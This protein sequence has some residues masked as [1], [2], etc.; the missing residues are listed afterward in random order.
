MALTEQQPST[1]AQP[2]PSDDAFEEV[3]QSF[4]KRLHGEQARLLV[5]TDALGSDIGNAALVLGDLEVFAHRLR[6]A[7]AVFDAG[8]LSEDAK[9][10]E[11]AVAAASIAPVR[12]ND[13]FVWAS[14]RTLTSRLASMNGTQLP[15]DCAVPTAQ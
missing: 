3:R 7:A 10:L 2:T 8:A 5:L 13:T 15:A 11:L 14:L 1:R 9:T 4:L 12:Q 6:G